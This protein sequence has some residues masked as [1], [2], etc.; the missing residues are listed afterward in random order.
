MGALSSLCKLDHVVCFQLPPFVCPVFGLNLIRITPISTWLRCE[1]KS[2]HHK[3]PI[4]LSTSYFDTT[5]LAFFFFNFVNYI[6]TRFSTLHIPALRDA[7]I[8]V[9]TSFFLIRH[10]R[11]RSMMAS[12]RHRGAVTSDCPKWL[13][14]WRVKRGCV[15][16]SGWNI[17]FSSDSAGP[18]VGDSM[19]R[20]NI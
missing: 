9:L 7:D 12:L 2:H 20:I 16:S 6:F 19:C 13:R 10:V 3:T 8:S 17:L 15:C 1:A 5:V 18:V 4:Q 14:G 11:R